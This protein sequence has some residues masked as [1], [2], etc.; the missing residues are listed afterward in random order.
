MGLCGVPAF[1]V[2]G[3]FPPSPCRA[4]LGGAQ[5]LCQRLGCHRDPDP[6]PRSASFVREH[7]WLAFPRCASP[8]L[9]RGGHGEGTPAQAHAVAHPAVLALP[10]PHP[11]CAS[12]R[13]GWPKWLLLGKCAHAEVPSVLCSARQERCLPHSTALRGFAGFDPRLHPAL[14]P[15][16]LTAALPPTRRP[17]PRCQQEAGPGGLVPRLGGVP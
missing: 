14:L 16:P 3:F 7:C 12:G 8:D 2:G 5:H 10:P 6:L 17:E 4:G 11:R 1:G 15:H 9:P 13:E